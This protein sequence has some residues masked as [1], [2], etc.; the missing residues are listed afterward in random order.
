MANLITLE[1]YKT[2]EGISSP[3]DDEKLESLITSISQLVKTYCGNSIVDYYTTNK[4]EYFSIPWD[5]NF[6]QVTESPLVRVSSV[7]EKN[8]S[9]NTYMDLNDDEYYVDYA[10]DSIFRVQKDTGILRDWPKG[11]G[12]VIVSYTAGYPSCP[13][14][15]KLAVVDLITYYH[16][17]EYKQR[18][19]LSGATRENPSSTTLR[20]S[21]AFPDHIKRVLDMYK[22]F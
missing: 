17:D 5:T 9:V 13:E 10:V 4:K 11:P 6:V 19:T 21:V 16:K 1:E 8:L 18:Q 12:A 2:F 15:L 7:Q 20:N 3:K 14:D 22:N